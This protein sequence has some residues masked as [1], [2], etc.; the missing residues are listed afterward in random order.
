M[1]HQIELGYLVLEV[2]EPEILTPAFADVVG[3]VAGES[4]GA[5]EPHV[6]E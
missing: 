2:P 4:T 6:A 3:L 5:G 1:D